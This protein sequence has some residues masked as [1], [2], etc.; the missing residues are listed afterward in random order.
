MR[1]FRNEVSWSAIFFIWT[2]ITLVWFL[3]GCAARSP[4]ITNFDSALAVK[5]GLIPVESGGF[6]KI[7][8]NA[9]KAPT[10]DLESWTGVTSEQGDPR[11]RVAVWYILKGDTVIVRR[12]DMLDA[13]YTLS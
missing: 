1:E 7:R 2:L 9:V 5:Q 12:R 11:L 3:T 10:V 8:R 4:V 6:T 13:H